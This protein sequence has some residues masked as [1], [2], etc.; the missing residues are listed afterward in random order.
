MRHEYIE[1]ILEADMVLVGIGSEFENRRFVK[2]DCAIAAIAELGKILENK[3]YFVITTC[4][5]SI[6]KDAGLKENRTVS[7]CGNTDMKQCPDHCENSLQLL[8][9]CEKA[10]LK[11]D[12]EQ[13]KEPELGCCS[14]C[15]K[16]LVLNNVY[17]AKYDEN[18]Y[19]PDWSIY[20]KWLQGSLNKKLCILELGVNL[21]FPSIIRW[22]FEKVAFYNQ[23]ATFFRV[24]EKLYHMSEELKDKG[25]SIAK[26]AIDWLLEKDI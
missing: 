6:L 19:L 7:P 10:T 1:K 24:N 20:T 22:P 23:K 2:E 25:I 3:N 17:A 5:N 16:P 13:E 21:D 12:L 8:T 9:D 11:S 15:G 26:N 18:G 14:V 4:T